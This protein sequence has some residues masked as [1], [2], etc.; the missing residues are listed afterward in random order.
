MAGDGSS[1]D[2][3]RELLSQV[4][5]RLDDRLTH[6]DDVLAE[7]RRHAR[8]T[9]GNLATAQADINDIKLWRA[10]LEGATIA[11]RWIPAAITAAIGTGVGGLIVLLVH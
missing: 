4:E 1:D 7:I 3:L 10:R 6:Q 2:L 11:V 5:K 8:A 9:N